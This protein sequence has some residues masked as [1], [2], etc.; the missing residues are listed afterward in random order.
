MAETGAEEISQHAGITCAK[1]AKNLLTSDVV[2]DSGAFELGEEISEELSAAFSGVGVVASV[3]AESHEGGTADAV[4][5]KAHGLPLLV[6]AR[7]IDEAG[8]AVW[9]EVMF[10][11]SEMVS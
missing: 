11:K 8:G 9:G 7:K 3:A 10:R 2:S 5:V 4:P 6:V 1:G